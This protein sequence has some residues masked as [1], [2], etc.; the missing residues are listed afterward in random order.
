MKHFPIYCASSLHHAP[1]WRE[2][3][4]TENLTFCARW[5]W[6]HCDEDGNPIWPESFAPIFWQHDLEDIQ[7]ASA[8]LCYALPSDFMRGA[9][10]ECGMALALGKN[11]ILCGNNK[12]FG[13]WQ[14]HPLVSRVD[15]MD[16]AIKIIN[17]LAL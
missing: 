6:H 17:L 10:V 9:L 3:A 4:R 7:K 8:L 5:P 2:L 12:G 13:T 15:S 16:D 11:V 1:L 14:Y